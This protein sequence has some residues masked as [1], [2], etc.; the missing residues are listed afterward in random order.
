[1]P[2]TPARVLCPHPLAPSHAYQRP[3]MH[4]DASARRRNVFSNRRTSCAAQRTM[5]HKAIAQY[6]HTGKASP[7]PS[8]SPCRGATRA[9]AAA[10]RGPARGHS[11]ER[12]AVEAWR[13][14]EGGGATERESVVAA[15]AHD[16]P[17]RT[18]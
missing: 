3:G 8:S 4:T 12:G 2:L 7:S 18:T 5:A 11:E 16:A 14:K 6:T 10:E 9:C 17:E 15:T 1:M 13:A